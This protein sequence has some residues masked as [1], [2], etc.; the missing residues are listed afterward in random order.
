MPFHSSS[1]CLFLVLVSSD[2]YFLEKYMYMIFKKFYSLWNCYFDLYVLMS[3]FSSRQF[4]S[5]DSIFRSHIRGNCKGCEYN[6]YTSIHSLTITFFSCQGLSLFFNY[7]KK[8]NSQ[9]KNPQ[10]LLFLC[11]GFRLKIEISSYAYMFYFFV[12]YLDLLT[13]IFTTI[14][15]IIMELY[16]GLLS[17]V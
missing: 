3:I 10:I 15:F 6:Q 17:G 5:L 7:L 11:L 14:L 16:I 12:A 4:P 9:Q 13:F 1:D 2:K 8:K